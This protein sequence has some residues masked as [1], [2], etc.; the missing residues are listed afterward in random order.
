LAGFEEEN[1]SQFH[2]NLVPAHAERK[3]R[4]FYLE[5]TQSI[6]TNSDLSHKERGAMRDQGDAVTKRG[7]GSESRNSSFENTPES[8]KTTNAYLR[9][10]EETI[11]MAARPRIGIKSCGNK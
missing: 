5:P 7:C 3:R 4:L 2:R 10:G 1:A 8:V 6:P 9:R 11:S